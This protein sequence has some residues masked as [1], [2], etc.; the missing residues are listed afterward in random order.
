MLFLVGDE[1]ADRACGRSNSPA[2]M[3]T[4]CAEEP[5]WLTDEE[6]AA[7]LATAALMITLPA[8]LDARLQQEAGLTF[9]EYMVLSVLS[10]RADRTMRMTHIAAGVS[11]SLSRLSHVAT[12]LEERGLLCRTRVA[13]SGRRT[14]AKLTELGYAKVVSAAPGH[15][16]AVRDLLLDAARPS[17][18][19]T[20]Q[21]IGT[22]VA[23]RISP[24]RPFHHGITA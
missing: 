22:A 14:N 17:D 7:W 5:R 4:E 23:A 24:E 18:L 21:R 9:F 8:A 10:E 6:R 2:A 19:A 1:E 11:A 13:G 15:V 16:T 12:R 3:S 20:L